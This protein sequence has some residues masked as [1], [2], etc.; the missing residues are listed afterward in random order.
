MNC[1]LAKM[2]VVMTGSMFINFDFDYFS[3]FCCKIEK[4]A[5]YDCPAGDTDVF[6]THFTRSFFNITTLWCDLNKLNTHLKI[7][8]K[9]T[10]PHEI[11]ALFFDRFNMFI[12]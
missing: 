11:L 6:F 4:T 2:L 12:F 5:F 3:F 8:Q 7:L 1:N 10:V 9:T